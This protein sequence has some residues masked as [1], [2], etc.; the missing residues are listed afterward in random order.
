[1]TT[2]ALFG[3]GAVLCAVLM[4]FLLALPSDAEAQSTSVRPPEG[5]QTWGAPSQV[6]TTVLPQPSDAEIK[7]V[8]AETERYI[9]AAASGLEKERQRI[10]I[11]PEEISSQILP[12]HEQL[13]DKFRTMSR[14]IS[15]LSTP[16]NER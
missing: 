12:I 4:V 16:S 1:M 3:L 7:A 11:L 10:F 8:D 13:S 15:R 6:P 2:R 14:A 9:E 5:T